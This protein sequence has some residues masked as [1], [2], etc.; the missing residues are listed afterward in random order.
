MIV[1]FGSLLVILGLA[2]L[3][4]WRFARW[5]NAAY[6][7]VKTGSEV[8]RT[9]RGP[10][11]YAMTG[12]GPVVLVLHGGAG[13]FDQGQF[14]GEDLRIHESFTLLAPSRAGYLRTPLE[15]CRTP[16]ETADAL[17]ALLDVLDIREVAVV[18]IS[19][20][21]PIALQMALRHPDRVRALVMLAAVSRRFVLPSRST[22]GVG[23]VFF[24]NTGMWLVDLMCWLVFVGTLRVRPALVATWF[25]KGS[26]TLDRAGIRQRVAQFMAD[27]EQIRWMRMLVDYLLPVSLRKTG[28]ENDLRQFAA[29]DEYPV[30]RIACPTLVIHGRHD[31]NVPFEHADFVADGVPNAR[32]HVVEGCGHLVWLS[33]RAK[34]VQSA[35]IGFLK[36]HSV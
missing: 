22:R 15:T 30:Q 32:L 2:A 35:V 12:E 29:I 19:G 24:S 33:E 9:A 31:G 10:V 11:E 26:E 5:R 34:E 13:G 18:G 20:G 28:M 4:L 17:A 8:A 14:L 7:R 25:F 27:P 3:V 6:E 23:R 1:G 36:E 21:G 16:Q